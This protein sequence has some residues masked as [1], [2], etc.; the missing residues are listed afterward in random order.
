MVHLAHRLEMDSAPY[1]QALLRMASFQLRCQLTPVS[2]L[3][4][5]RP[6]LAVG[7]FRRSLTNWEVRID[8][9]QHNLS[10]LLGL[11]AILLEEG[12][13]GPDPS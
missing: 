5:P 6:D 1:R 4:L 9:V 12:G 7:G 3:Y 10:A 11:R 8:Y 13:S 2:S